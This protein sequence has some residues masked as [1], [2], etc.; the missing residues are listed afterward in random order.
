VTLQNSAGKSASHS[1]RL[2][3]YVG[4]HIAYCVTLESQCYSQSVQAEIRGAWVTVAANISFSDRSSVAAPTPWIDS[5]RTNSPTVTMFQTPVYAKK[6]R[7]Q[8][9]DHF[10]NGPAFSEVVLLLDNFSTAPP[11]ITI[12]SNVSTQAILTGVQQFQVAG[13]SFYSYPLAGDLSVNIS[14]DFTVCSLSQN[15]VL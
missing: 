11:R 14:T 15:L 13:T 10:A 4:S 12:A 9:V 3:K 1:T 8:H 2:V 6:W 7:L 5:R